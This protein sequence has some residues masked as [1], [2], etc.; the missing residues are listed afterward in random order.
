M[1]I[2]E[3]NFISNEGQPSFSNEGTGM[4]SF[5]K[6]QTVARRTFEVQIIS[7]SDSDSDLGVNY[8]LYFLQWSRMAQEILSWMV[9]NGF[10][11]SGLF[12]KR[13]SF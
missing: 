8:G 9:S 4:V 1:L 5:W 7:I 6:T 13:P 11:T 2:L 10:F 3:L 12:Y